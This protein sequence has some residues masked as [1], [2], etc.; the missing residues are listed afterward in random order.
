MAETTDVSNHHSF[1][2]TSGYEATRAA[3]PADL[4]SGVTKQL[5]ESFCERHEHNGVRLS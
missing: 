2:M 5:K 3:E 4:N 1:K